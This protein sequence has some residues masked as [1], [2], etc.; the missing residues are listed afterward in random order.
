[1]TIRT[2]KRMLMTCVLCL[3]AAP[4]FA[5]G[6]GSGSSVFMEELT[7]K[8]IQ[9]KIRTGTVTAIV[10]TGGTEQ[11]GPHIATGRQN[12]VVRYTAGQIAQGVNGLVAPVINYA[13]EGRI[14]PPEGHMQFPGTFSISQ[15]TFAGI[16][17]DTAR[18]LKQH[19]FRYICFI[20]EHRGSQS[21]QQQV[22]DKL[23]SMWH[24]EGVR[25]INV[26]HYFGRNGQEE[27]SDQAGIKVPNPEAHAGHIETSEI[28]ALD[29]AGVRDN[30]RLAYTERDY[31]NT[32]AMGDSTQASAKY[33]RRYLGLKQEAAIKQI[34]NAISANE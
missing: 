23:T 1:M 25:V 34:K 2:A 27:W 20:G 10:P 15:E 32:G 33:G 24:S 12:T 22:A 17:E 31:K 14:S 18:S 5:I 19:G 28:M 16:L 7:W 11:G 3:W 4:A 13:P 29:P 6:M 30:L 9:S 21:V 8:E 26:S